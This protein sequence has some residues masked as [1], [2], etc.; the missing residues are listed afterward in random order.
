MNN[1]FFLLLL[2]LIFSSYSKDII[3]FEFDEI[4]RGTLTNN[5]YDYYSLTLPKDLDKDSYLVIELEP[6]KYLD[7]IS[8]IVS[9]PNLYVSMTEKMPSINSNTWKSE[10]FGDET[11]SISPSLLSPQQNI[12]ISVHCNEKCNYIL[13][14]QFVKDI[15]IKENGIYNF[16]INPKTVTK[17][18]FTTRENFNELYLNIISSTISSF[19]AYLAKEN[20]SSTNT[21]VATPIIFNGYRFTINNQDTTNIN[22][23]YHLIIDNE[24]DRHDLTIWLQYDNEKLLVKEADILYDSISENKAHC[25]Y[26]PIDYF[27]ENKEIIISMN[28]FNGQGFIHMA[29]YNPINADSIRL[30]DKNKDTNYIVIQNKVIRLTKDNFKNFGTFNH[31]EQNF[32][33]F[34]FYAE[35]STS[36]SLKVYFLENYKRLQALNIVYAGIVIEDILPKR[37]LKK[38]KLEHFNIDQDITLYLEEK[39]GNPKLYLFMAKPGEEN[40]IINNSDFEKYKRNNQIMEAKHIHNT[41]NLYLT[42][43]LNKCKLN[44][45]IG[46][47]P[48]YLSVI[49]ECRGDEDCIYSFSFD[50]S[51]D[52]I[53]MEQK[54]TYSNVISENE[55]DYYKIVILDESVK[56]LVIVLM[57]NTGKALLRL[58]SFTSESEE[59][60]LNE[61]TQNNQFLPN[62]IKISSEKLKR[63]N[64]KG[65]FNLK[66]KGLSYASYSLYYYTFNNEENIDQ[67]DHEKVSMKLEKGKIIKDIFM[68]THRFKVYMYDSSTIGNKTNLFI[69]LV[70]TNY[71]N[72]ELFVFKDLNDFSIYD[73]KIRGYLWKGDLKDYIYIDKNDKNYIE[74]DILYIMIFKK[75]SFLSE[76]KEDAYTSF[77]LGITDENT[78]LLLHDGVEFKYQLNKEHP[79]QKFYYYFVDNGEKDQDLQISISLYYGHV[80]V[81]FE[82]ENKIYQGKYV[83]DDSALI[84]IK[85]ED[86]LPYCKK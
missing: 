67:L 16:I 59:L 41:Y 46:L 12:Y 25:Y 62:L 45:E 78:P 36:L 32:L 72:L 14:T 81:L 37:S 20:P 83:F 85:R 9:D 31:N 52:P 8:N 17:F 4:R 54:K 39:Y 55:F 26:Y 82:I 63:D 11:I 57:Q 47:Y 2:I 7:S 30:T 24:D 43:E 65:I 15:P 58:D 21:L 28:L 3:Q 40:L 1:G 6:S 29:G 35:K 27:N 5:E 68:D 70:E 71:I 56:N 86:I 34:C 42:K 44:K 48:C 84:T 23:K 75:Q 60:N 73:E 53:N 38:Y 51:K 19:N 10:R 50:H 13:K 76:K 69:G 74:N 79:S 66:V 61:E 64:L 18:S 33:N 80:S 77:Y 49:I 22:T